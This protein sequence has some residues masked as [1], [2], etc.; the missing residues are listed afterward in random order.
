MYPRLITQV[1]LVAFRAPLLLDAVAYACCFHGILLF[2][3]GGLELDSNHL[4]LINIH[5]ESTTTWPSLRRLTLGS[6]P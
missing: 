6:I 1:G 4:F 5:M 2:N 3:L